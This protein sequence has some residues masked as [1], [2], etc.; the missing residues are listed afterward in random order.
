[1]KIAVLFVIGSMS[2]AGSLVFAAGAVGVEASHIGDASHFEFTGRTD[3]K[4]DLKR[5]ESGKRV[6]LSLAG[7]KPEALAKLRSHKDALIQGVKIDENGVD[8]AASVSF[9]VGANADF[10]DYIAEG[11]S[12]LIVDFFPNEADK[13][14]PKKKDGA[15]KDANQKTA[16]ADTSEK[17][18]HSLG[19]TKDI[20]A[21]ITGLPKKTKKADREPAASDLPLTATEAPPSH[22]EEVSSQKDFSHGIFDGGDPDFRRFT[23][24][25]YEVNEDSIFKSRGN[26]YLPFPMLELGN[27]QLKALIEAPPTY[28][29]VP[30]E[31]RENKEARVLLTLFST[32]KRALF[33]TTSAEFLKKYPASQYDEIV[34]YM[35][36]DLHET[37]WR[38][39]GSANDFETAMTSYQSL[40]EKYPDSPV[41]PRTLLFIG[42]SYVERGDSF[43]A[44]KAFQRFTR[45]NP[46]SKYVDPVN[47]AVAESYLRLNRY[48]DAMK[49]L[50]Q[51]ETTAKTP[52][53]RED[54]SFRKGDI[55]FKQ[56]DYEGAL[57]L[58]RASILK[59]PT[60]IT[61][62]PN[63]YYN[64]AEAEF[65][66]GQYRN[67]L[68]DYRIFLQKFPD[69]AHGGYAMT[70]MGELIGILG[71]DP[72]R[73]QGAFAESFFRYRAT[74]GA[75]I[76]RIRTLITRFP[77][78]KDK[79]LKAAIKEIGEIT[80]KYVN[81]PKGDGERKPASEAAAVAKEAPKAEGKKEEKKEEGKDVKKEDVAADEPKKENLSEKKPEL[82]GIEEF[83]TLLF[84]DGYN[85]RKE[86]DLAAKNLITYYQKNPQT[87]NKDRILARIAKNI[88]EKIGQSV[89]QGDFMEGLRRYGK[90]SS[91]WLKNTDRV[92]VRYSVGRAYEQAGVLK[93]AAASYRDCLKRLADIK[94]AGQV[95]E[96]SVYEV[97]PKADQLNLRLAS[98]SARDKEYSQ[99]ESYLKNVS[100]PGEL[101]QA[102]QIERAETA[103]DVA[104][105][106]GQAAAAKKYL[107]DLID[108]WKGDA[109]L[110]SPL[111]LRIARLQGAAKNFK[112]A[113][114]HL[115]RIFDLRKETGKVPDDVVAQALQL[116][117]EQMVARGNRA[118]AVKA[119]GELL[120]EFGDTRPLASVR[121]R[122]GQ[123]KYEDG[124]LKGAQST[125]A[126]LKPDKD[127]MWAKLAAEQM[128]SAKWQNDYK[129]YINRIP[130]ASELR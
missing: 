73:A 20:S 81:R 5:D 12:R 70:R 130:A 84:A 88:S 100:V 56:K 75:G 40:A 34:R 124:D 64:I 41:T 120:N 106:R 27:P 92:D 6:V 108:A 110:T 79:E 63:A 74:P 69:H 62:F 126:E 10:F 11:P 65:T 80:E 102:E 57:K 119:Y 31:T 123:L 7:L 128:Q 49:M 118:E 96:H 1:M 94:A 25:D 82:P 19:S 50:E 86:Y 4:Y 97:L 28:E 61:R 127:G 68:E 55:A 125:W 45:L 42:Y 32:G 21:L 33:L 109:A 67:A 105:A 44:L 103:A 99:A 26:Y 112:D 47:I 18:S 46:T 71:A 43:G 53:V 58:Y 83:T 35:I 113:D 8:G 115:S 89:E 122:L 14:T 30:N 13:K 24:K 77:E 38:E 39:E 76:A 15:A 52:K 101:T 98:V 23:V 93:D 60:A 66:K 114:L 85:A 72:K 36:A 2:C 29:I 37:M 59:Y 17:G 16:D 116:R 104:E 87:S 54:A 51:I 111:H 78:M 95:R 22:A 9:A 3:W 90:E 117:G 48:D 91:G 121:Y 107:T 129:K